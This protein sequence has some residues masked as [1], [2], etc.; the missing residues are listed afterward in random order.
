MAL[1]AKRNN[2]MNIDSIERKIKS[3]TLNDCDTNMVS[4][5]ENGSKKK[6][7]NNFAI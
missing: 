5:N 2:M 3:I 7:I 6:T 1:I 4:P